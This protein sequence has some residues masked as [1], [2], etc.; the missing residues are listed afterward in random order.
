MKKL[1]LTVSIIV[2][3]FILGNQPQSV[4]TMRFRLEKVEQRLDDIDKRL[5]FIEEKLF[6]TSS[7]IKTDIEKTVEETV[8]SML[9][10]GTVY[11]I[12]LK[13]GQIRVHYDSWNLLDM[14]QKKALTMMFSDYMFLKTGNRSILVLKNNSPK[15]L[16]RYN[17]EIMDDV[18]IYE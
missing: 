5:Q 12:D 17:T 1:L 10:R 3:L 2:T 4:G 9:V 11:S 7:D 13:S 14:S 6:P 16:A 18:K 15:V 8:E